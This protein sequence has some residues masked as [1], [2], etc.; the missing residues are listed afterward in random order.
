WLWTMA[1][2]SHAGLPSK[3]ER[4]AVT[5]SAQ[6][7]P[8]AP[9]PAPPAVTPP[10]PVATPPPLLMPVQSAPR[11]AD[12]LADPGVARD[13][14]TALLSLYGRWGADT[15]GQP[16]DCEREAVAGL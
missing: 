13:K 15:R 7:A 14:P 3:V 6:A 5:T 2:G 1:V 4:V 12:V 8:E 16:L 11:L 9:T 10:A